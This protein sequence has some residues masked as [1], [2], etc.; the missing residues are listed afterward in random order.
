MIT[1]A[2]MLLQFGGGANGLI[3]K[4]VTLQHESKKSN[5]EKRR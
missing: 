3:L 2:C 4:T 1:A 5:K